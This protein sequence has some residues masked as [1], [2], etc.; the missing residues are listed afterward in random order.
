MVFAYR[1]QK[2]LDSDEELNALLNFFEKLNKAEALKRA[3]EAVSQIDIEKLVNFFDEIE[4]EGSLSIRPIISPSYFENLHH[5]KNSQIYT[6]D[7]LQEQQFNFLRRYDS[8]I[9]DKKFE[10]FMKSVKEEGFD[11]N[12]ALK[13][14][15]TGRKRVA[16]QRFEAHKTGVVR[17]GYGRQEFNKDFGPLQDLINIDYLPENP[18]DKFL[19]NLGPRKEQSLHQANLIDE[20][21]F[22]Y[23]KKGAL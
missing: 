15:L 14:A 12:L 13:L 16:E 20:M 9:R 1:F 22:L 21:A 5:S 18:V 2:K 4:S 11:E 19:M 23:Y 17:L 10:I 7:V 3:K 6:L 8:L